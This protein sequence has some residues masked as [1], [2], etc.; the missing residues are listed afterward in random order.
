MGSDGS[1]GLHSN[2]RMRRG[3]ITL[4][5]DSLGRWVESQ[6]AQDKYV[7]VSV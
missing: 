2:V 4:N 3:T 6:G 1:R 5:V 7:E